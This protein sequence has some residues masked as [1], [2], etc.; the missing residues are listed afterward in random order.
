M[1][2]SH[3]IFGLIGFPLGHSFSRT[4]F[5]EMFSKEKINAEY[6]NFEI[7][8]IK[9][10]PQILSGHPDLCGFNVT[11]PYKTDIIKYLDNIS[12]EAKRI[13]AVN[14]V[15]IT[16]SGNGKV[17]L[18]GYNTDVTGFRESIRKYLPPKPLK[19]LVLGSGGASKAIVEGLRALSI[20]S[21]VVSRNPSAGQLSYSDL[22]EDI[23]L[24]NKVIVNTTPLGMFPNIQS[25]P[26]I[27]Y[28]FI[29]PDHICFDAVYN[30][31]QTL[32]LKKCK[33]RGAIT[34]NGLEMLHLQAISSWEIWNSH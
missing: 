32:F 9:Y 31:L 16:R 29:S 30:P 20:P 10:L 18:S 3:R 1:N 11:I 28:S 22:T 27:P 17:F 14:T 33:D 21:T 26:D 4:F 24:R 8:S 34:I 7:P 23:I 13:G 15:T 25:C 2:E 12:P 6:L 19:A 5:T